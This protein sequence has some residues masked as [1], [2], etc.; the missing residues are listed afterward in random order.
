MREREFPAAVGESG[1]GKS[2]IFLSVLGLLSR[3]VRCEI[4]GEV[5]FQGRDLLALSGEAL[6]LVR[7]REL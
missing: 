7:G 4:S 3:M 2:V 6:R 1:S 5:E